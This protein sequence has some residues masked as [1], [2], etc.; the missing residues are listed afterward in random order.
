MS[1]LWPVSLNSSLCPLPVGS[2]KEWFW[3][4]LLLVCDLVFWKLPG[5]MNSGLYLVCLFCSNLWSVFWILDIWCFAVLDSVSPVCTQRGFYPG[6]P[7]HDHTPVLCINLSALLSTRHYCS[8]LQTFV[9][10]D[11]WL[12]Y[13]YLGGEQVWDLLCCPTE[14]WFLLLVCRRHVAMSVKEEKLQLFS[15]WFPYL[16]TELLFT[17]L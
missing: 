5:F 17:D 3:I 13:M 4:L 16:S 2:F 8:L 1:D 14:I 15:S 12:S 9:P 7:L 10:E 6:S 11:L